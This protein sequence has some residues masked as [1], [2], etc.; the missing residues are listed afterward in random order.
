M[1]IDR[2]LH[3]N[4]L[5]I[6]LLLASSICYAEPTA[7][8]FNH[9]KGLSDHLPREAAIQHLQ[10]ELSAYDQKR[11]QI[12]GFL[13]RS[14]EGNWILSAEPNLMTCCVNKQDKIGRIIFVIGSS[15]EASPSQAVTVEGL[16]SINPAWDQNGNLKQ[17]YVLNNAT[18]LPTQIS[19]STLALSLIAFLGFIISCILIKCALA[20]LPGP[21][22]A[23]E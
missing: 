21:T 13:Y 11:V 12:R 14:D 22:P 23:H 8:S 2:F 9:L 15:L 20:P 6:F 16:L 4:I 10:R 18:V 17:I 1:L 19:R 5:I 3:S 7:L